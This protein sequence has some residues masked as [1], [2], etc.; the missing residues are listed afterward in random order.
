[1]MLTLV[2]YFLVSAMA[3][4]SFSSLFFFFLLILAQPTDDLRLVPGARTDVDA[5]PREGRS[6]H[7]ATLW[8]GEK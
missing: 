1:M 3:W 4:V 8:L 5:R 6:L 7:T 2:D